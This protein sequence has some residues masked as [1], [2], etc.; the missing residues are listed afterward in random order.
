MC[1]NRVVRFQSIVRL[2]DM[3]PTIVG[4]TKTTHCVGYRR[5]TR[6]APLQVAPCCFAVGGA[7]RTSTTPYGSQEP[8][9]RLLELTSTR[10]LHSHSRPDRL[11]QTW[12]I[13]VLFRRDGQWVARQNAFGSPSRPCCWSCWRWR[14]YRRRLE[15]GCSTTFNSERLPRNTDRTLGSSL[16]KVDQ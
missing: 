12:Q 2:A 15:G 5:A 7:S 13:Q 9:K 8:V 16:W 11:T 4:E 1:I 10:K 6:A 3:L 14:A